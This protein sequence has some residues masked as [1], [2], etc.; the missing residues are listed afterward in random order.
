MK[1]IAIASYDKNKTFEDIKE[2]II[3]LKPIPPLPGQND[4]WS[5]LFDDIALDW[6][7]V[8]YVRRKHLRNTPG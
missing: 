6:W 5:I 4:I 7:L 1:N 2:E 3:S 8:F